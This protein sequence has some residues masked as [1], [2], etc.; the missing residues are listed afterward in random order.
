MSLSRFLNQRLCCV[1]NYLDL[2]RVLPQLPHLAD[3]FISSPFYLLPF[4]NLTQ[5]ST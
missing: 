1:T 5:T 4:V 2:Y 3:A